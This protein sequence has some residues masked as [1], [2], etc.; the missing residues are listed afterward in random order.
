MKVV[1]SNRYHRVNEY[2]L[3]AGCILPSKVAKDLAC[4]HNMNRGFTEPAV[5]YKAVSNDYELKKAKVRK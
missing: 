2:F 4:H 5:L 1:Y 3:Y